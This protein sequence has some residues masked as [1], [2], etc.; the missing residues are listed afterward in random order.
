MHQS[1]HKTQACTPRLNTVKSDLCPLPGHTGIPQPDVATEELHDL[2]SLFVGFRACDLSICNHVVYHIKTLHVRQYRW[3][4]F[5]LNSK[6][7]FL[8]V[9]PIFHAFGPDEVFFAQNLN[10]PPPPLFFTL[11]SHTPFWDMYTTHTH[12]PTPQLSKHP[13]SFVQDF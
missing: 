8:E 7:L 6:A 10:P 2:W 12:H 5:F 1:T 13:F 3:M 11:P 9:F 4:I